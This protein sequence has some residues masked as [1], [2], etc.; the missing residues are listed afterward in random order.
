MPGSARRDSN[1]F[2]IDH[3]ALRAVLADANRRLV[4]RK[5]ELCSALPRVPEVLLVL[6]QIARAKVFAKQLQDA[7]RES[8]SS[9]LSDGRPFREATA[10]VTAFFRQI[11]EPL[12]A[13]VEIIGERLTEAALRDRN[14][15]AG[16]DRSV[17]VGVDMSGNEVVASKPVA[18]LGSG[19]TSNRSRLGGRWFAEKG[20]GS[21]SAQTLFH[22]R[23]PDDSLQETPCCPR[24]PI[25][26][27]RHL[28]AVGSYAMERLA[29]D[30]S[31]IQVHSCQDAYVSSKLMLTGPDELP[32]PRPH[33]FLV[34]SNPFGRTMPMRCS[35][36][37]T[38]FRIGSLRML[39]APWASH[40]AVRASMLSSVS[41]LVTTGS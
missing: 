3:D 17:S 16:P 26:H 29:D 19:D 21:R 4:G 37:V 2:A 22:R 23:V 41:I 7:I 32:H 36:P 24:A 28:Q 8:R 20:F 1:L 10:T 27:W 34:N 5:D 9:R 31:T 33:S 6:D 35:A 12:Q 18:S 40:F 11:D 25:S 13:A 30:S 14:N 38:G 15:Q 39:A